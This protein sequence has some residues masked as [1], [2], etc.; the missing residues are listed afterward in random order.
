MT[1]RSLRPPLIAL[2]VLA[3]L[4]LRK[5]NLPLW[6]PDQMAGAPF[7]ALHSPGVLYPPNVLL[8]GMLRPARA[9]AAHALRAVHALLSEP[10]LG[11]AL[12][13][14]VVV[15]LAFLAGYSQGFLFEMQLA[16]VYG[17]FGL[18]FIASRGARPRIL[19]GARA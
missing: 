17:L 2:A 6:N 12:A 9:L 18:F 13:L 15:S 8:V 16:S 5:G 11:R 3:A 19:A 14:A 1:L 4:E 7:L 10:R